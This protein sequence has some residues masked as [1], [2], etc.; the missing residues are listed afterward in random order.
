[1]AEKFSYLEVAC[2]V[3]LWKLPIIPK[4]STPTPRSR[5][6][7]SEAI[8]V[9]V[10]WAKE[11]TPGFKLSWEGTPVV[12]LVSVL[13]VRDGVKHKTLP[14]L[15]EGVLLK[16]GLGQA[17]LRPIAVVGKGVATGSAIASVVCA[18]GV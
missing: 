9:W 11:V 17:G 16:L 10:C 1:M 8:G 7:A 14:N 3:D 2:P 13:I 12:L 5:E 15:L 6:L 4:T 18:E